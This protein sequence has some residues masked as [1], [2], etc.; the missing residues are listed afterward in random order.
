MI[1]SAILPA[2]RPTRAQSSFTVPVAL[3]SCGGRAIFAGVVHQGRM[4]AFGRVPASVPGSHA[5]ALRARIG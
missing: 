1:S 3:R 5:G 2:S 4:L